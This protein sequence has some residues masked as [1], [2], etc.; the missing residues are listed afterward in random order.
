[1]QNQNILVFCD[2]LNYFKMLALESKPEVKQVIDRHELFIMIRAI[3]ISGRFWGSR[4]VSISI[5]NAL[6]ASWWAL[7]TLDFDNRYSI[8]LWAVPLQISG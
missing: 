6:K 3:Q 5:L 8:K 2:T 7:P 4:S 1:M